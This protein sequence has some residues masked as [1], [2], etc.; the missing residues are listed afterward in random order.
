MKPQYV[1]TLI[2]VILVG[3]ALVFMS[4]TTG[5]VG[6]VTTTTE[7]MTK[8]FAK[9]DADAS[10]NIPIALTEGTGVEHESS[11]IFQAL[12]SLIGVKQA[13]IRMDGTAIVVEYASSETNESTIVSAL[14]SAGYGSAAQGQ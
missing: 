11:H 4:V 13:T 5:G 3:A 1:V 7:G 12:Q 14:A 9:V 6:T 10:A 2:A 8:V